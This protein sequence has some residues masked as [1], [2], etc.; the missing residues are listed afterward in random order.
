V[1]TRKLKRSSEA[2]WLLIAVDG[3]GRVWLERRPQQG[4][5][6]GLYAPPVF[7]EREAL[8]Q[9]AARHWPAARSADWTELPAFLHVLTHRDLHL[10]P[11][12]VP[13]HGSGPDAAMADGQ[14]CW[15]DARAWADMGLPAPVRKLL[16]AQFA[17]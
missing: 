17:G 16:D 15:A 14:G 2:W 7:N 5:W 11:V 13:V 9:A 1:R 10:H 3:Q 6:A 4:I 12:R 8:E